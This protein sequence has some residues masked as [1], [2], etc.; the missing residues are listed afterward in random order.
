[1]ENYVNPYNET[2][3]IDNTFNSWLYYFKQVSNYNLKEVY[4]SKN[5]VFSRD[6][7][8][9]KMSYRI[10]LDKNFENFKNKEISIKDKYKDFLNN[11]MK[12]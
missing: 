2:K 1:M 3:S 10:H 4:K 9:H 8:H 6:D 7:F 5:V 11:F 12:S